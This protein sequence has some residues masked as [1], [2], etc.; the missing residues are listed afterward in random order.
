LASASLQCGVEAIGGRLLILEP[1]H[2]SLLGFART[3]G[4]A[5]CTLRRVKQNPYSLC[6]I[7]VGVD[8]PAVNGDCFFS[9][10]AA[11]L[12]SAKNQPIR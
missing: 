12:E 7:S 8:C 6:D 9:A 5:R 3:R 2:L 4:E 1:R 10:C 11:A